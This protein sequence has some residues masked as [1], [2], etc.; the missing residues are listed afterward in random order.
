M[1]PTQGLNPSLISW[2]VSGMP[3]NDNAGCY[4]LWNL[5][6]KLNPPLKGV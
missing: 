4:I 6:Y 3:V 2:G 1:D 5:K